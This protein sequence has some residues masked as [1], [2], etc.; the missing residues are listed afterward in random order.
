MTASWKDV[1]RDRAR[2]ATVVRTGLVGTGPEDAFDRLIELAADLVGVPRGCITLVDAER[3]TAKSVLGFPEGAPTFAPIEQSFCRFVVGSGRPLIVDDA[4]S[5]PR[6]Q[7]DPAIAAFDA[8]TWAGFPL[9]AAD[10]TVLGT[11][12]L[13]DSRPHDWTAK[14]LHIIATL[15]QA[16]SSEIALRVARADAEV[17]HGQAESLRATMQSDNASLLGYLHELVSVAGPAAEGA[18]EVL[19]WLR[20]DD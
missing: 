17:A 8:V 20:A 13:M 9:E 19:R 16:A 14:D 10:G 18:R 15:A 12:C 5:D 1:V 7:G 2:V 6:T 4:R 3:T 11:F